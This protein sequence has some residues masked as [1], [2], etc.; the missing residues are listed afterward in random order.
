MTTK[1]VYLFDTPDGGD[2][3]QDLEIRDG[4]ETSVYLSLFGG[5]VKDDGSQDNPFGWWG[6]VGETVDAKKYV[7]ETA[8]LLINEPPTPKNL[9]RIEDAAVRDLTWMISEGVTE[10]IRVQA[11]MPA[12]NTVKL[13][14]FAE[15]IDPLEFRSSWTDK[16]GETPSTVVLPPTVLANDGVTLYGSGLPNATLRLTR[17]NGD[18]ITVP[19]SPLGMWEIA[20][21]PLTNGEV[22]TIAI[23][24]GSGLSSKSVVVVGVE[25]LLYNDA[26]LYDGTQTFSGLKAH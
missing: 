20:P 11:S 22:V 13:R 21:Y 18:I 4:L 19:V 24:T 1:D 26:V 15:G 3:M 5:N 16:I 7:S 25:P 10:T 12:L 2:L 6:N 17:A 9:R 14:V 8:Y 23:V